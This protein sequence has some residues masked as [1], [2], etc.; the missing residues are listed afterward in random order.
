M[1][2]YRAYYDLPSLG[3]R[4]YLEIDAETESDAMTQAIAKVGKPDE[5]RLMGEEET[6]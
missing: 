6:H 5:L 2:T 1:N 3:K 4:P